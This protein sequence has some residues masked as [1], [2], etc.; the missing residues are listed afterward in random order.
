MLKEDEATEGVADQ[1]V[2]DGGIS[3]LHHGPNGMD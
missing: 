1:P 2:N 3:G